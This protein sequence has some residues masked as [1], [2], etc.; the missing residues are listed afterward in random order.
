M[1]LIDALNKS[2][3]PVIYAGYGVRQTGAY[4][5]LSDVAHMLNIPVLLSWKGADVLEDDDMVFCGRPG[6]YGQHAANMIIQSCDLLLVMGARLRPQLTG[7]GEFA[8][9]AVKWIVDI[10]QNDLGIYGNEWHKLNTDLVSVLSCM[11]IECKQHGD[12][13]GQNSWLNKCRTLY[14]ESRDLFWNSGNP[15]Y[16]IIRDIW[17]KSGEGDVV[18]YGSSGQGICALLQSW[19]VKRDQRIMATNIGAMGSWVGAIGAAYASNKHVICL[20]GDGGFQYSTSDYATIRGNNLDI[21]VHV[22][23]NSGYASIKATQDRFFEGRHIGIT[24]E[25]GVYMSDFPAGVM[26][27]KVPI[28]ATVY[29]FTDRYEN[30][31]PH[32]KDVDSVMAWLK[33]GV[34]DYG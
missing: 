20:V 12:V 6:I 32:I 5:Q 18:A 31:T 25:T 17:Q 10:D 4:G 23:N 15:L 1:N 24:P 22:I 29:R 11:R 8:P 26:V 27:H 21:D 30:M 13:Y 7:Y 16:S 28:D 2:S 19:R 9:Q 14:Q 3:R 34:I 33:R